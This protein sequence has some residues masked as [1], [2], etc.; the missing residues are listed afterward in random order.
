MP[1]RFTRFGEFFIQ[2]LADALAEG[3]PIDVPHVGRC[4]VRRIGEP[5]MGQS[6][7]STQVA[8]AFPDSYSEMT[9]VMYTF[10]SCLLR[11]TETIPLP[12]PTYT[13]E[14]DDQ[15][16]PEHGEAWYRALELLEAKL[17]RA[18]F[19]VGSSDDCD[20]YL[21]TDYMPS[22]G[23]SASVL[24]PAALR[25]D[26]ISICRSVVRAEPS[27]NF[28]IRLALEFSDGR[29]NGHNEN[30]LVRPD[31]VVKD[32]DARRLRAVFGQEIPLLRSSRDA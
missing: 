6:N 13:D 26:L 3:T 10:G 8:I 5:M 11:D 7:W 15:F 18:G 9:I 19:A 2:G 24:K 28:W 21:I 16:P 30:V 1:T 31:R 12:E 23:I 22:Q 27:W 14:R 4:K 32:F 20:L 29:H 17:E 25:K